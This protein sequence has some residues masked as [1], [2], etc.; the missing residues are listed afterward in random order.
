MGGLQGGISAGPF[1]AGPTASSAPTAGPVLWPGC[2]HSK[3][4]WPK[5]DSVSEVPSAS[6][7]SPAALAGKLICRCLS[8]GEARK[9]SL[10]PFATS[11]VFLNAVGQLPLFFSSQTCPRAPRS[12]LAVEPGVVGGGGGR[13]SWLWLFEVAVES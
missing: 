9:P 10:S 8:E 13:K 6:S 7:W 4:S 5:R 11:L 2:T 3:L 1:G 12:L